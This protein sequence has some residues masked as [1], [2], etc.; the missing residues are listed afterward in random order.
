MDL[1]NTTLSCV[2]SGLRIQA[3]LELGM[4]PDEVRSLIGKPIEIN[5]SGTNWEYGQGV[6]VPEVTFN[7]V[8]SNGA[9]VPDVVSTFESHT[10]SCE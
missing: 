10:S 8:A 7:P 5:G 4:T 9:L 6:F 2:E 1:T 3:Y